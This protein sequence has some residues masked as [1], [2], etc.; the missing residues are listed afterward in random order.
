MIEAKKGHN[1]MCYIEALQCLMEAAPD[2]PEAQRDLDWINKTEAENKAETA[3]LENELKGYTNNL[4]KESIRV[5]HAM[6]I[7]KS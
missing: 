2:V 1:V 4:I 5:C 6:V 7:H 3:R